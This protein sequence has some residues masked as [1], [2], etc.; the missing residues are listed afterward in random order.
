MT[1][2]S[3]IV[4]TVVMLPFGKLG[5]L[6]KGWS[7]SGERAEKRAMVGQISVMVDRESGAGSTGIQST[8]DGKELWSE[9][10][11]INELAAHPRRRNTFFFLSDALLQLSF[12]KKRR[13][14]GQR[15]S[16]V[17]KSLGS[18]LISWR[19]S[20]FNLLFNMFKTCL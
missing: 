6:E 8:T 7:E 1:V 13:S 9:L 18:R 4:R 2:W 5:L 3:D 16:C 12:T 20:Q 14:A 17:T 10:I 19:Q 15:S 11:E